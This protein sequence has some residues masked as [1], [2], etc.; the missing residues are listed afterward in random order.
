MSVLAAWR[1]CKTSPA[2]TPGSHGWLP[3]PDAWHTRP[4]PFHWY[5]GR[6]KCA[7]ST[8]SILL[9]Q[10]TL[11]TRTHWKKKKTKKNHYIYLWE[12]KHLNIY[13]ILHPFCSTCIYCLKASAIQLI[14]HVH[15]VKNIKLVVVVVVFIVCARM[16][17]WVVTLAHIHSI[18]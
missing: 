12:N 5:H 8:R 13:K 6:P 9:N 10:H 17:A 2:P 16:C 14:F 18:F 15:F 4:D 11:S 7:P 1:E 3:Y